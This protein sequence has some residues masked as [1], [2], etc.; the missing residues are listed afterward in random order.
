MTQTQ[1]HTILV[2]LIQQLR[3]QGSWCGEADIQKSAYF[4][5]ELLGVPLDLNTIFY[6]ESPYLPDLGDEITAL[7][8]ESLLTVKSREPYGA[9]LWPTE[10][11]QRL[12]DHSPTTLQTYGPAVQFVAER[13]GPKKVAEVGQLATALYVLRQMP[14]AGRNEQAREF[15]R[16]KPHVTHDEALAALQTVEEMRAELN[17]VKTS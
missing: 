9:S 7:R 8:C 6:K 12:L 13:L 2:S 3:Q 5:Q 15:K 16:L 10:Q 17:G 4:L 1:R 14:D 11:A